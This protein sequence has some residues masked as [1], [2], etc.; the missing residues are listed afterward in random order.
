MKD[1]AILVPM[2]ALPVMEGKAMLFKDFF[3][4]DAFLMSTSNQNI[5]FPAHLIRKWGKPCQ[6]PLTSRPGKRG[7]Q[8]KEEEKIPEFPNRRPIVLT[9]PKNI[10][11]Q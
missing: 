3:G 10:E 5:L 9:D 6:K 11:E 1:M 2:V 7:W 8:E 4:V